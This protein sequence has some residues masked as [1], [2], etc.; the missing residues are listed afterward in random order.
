[1]SEKP[2]QQCHEKICIAEK[3]A[4]GNPYNSWSQSRG[5]PD[6]TSLLGTI[7][8]HFLA[9][10]LPPFVHEIGPFWPFQHE[11]ERKAKPY[12]SYFY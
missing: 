7:S 2:V 10:F 5:G 9:P 4:C 11:R 3:D 8:D 6:T 12:I 1:M